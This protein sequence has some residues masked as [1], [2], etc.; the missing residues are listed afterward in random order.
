M[1]TF[2]SAG[3]FEYQFKTLPPYRVVCKICHLP[4]RH[5]HLTV[6]CGHVFC[7]S[8]LDELEN[9]KSIVNNICP[10][11]RSE[12]FV[13]FSNKQIDRE[14]KSLLVYCTNKGRG[15]EWQGEVNYI[16]NHLT[17]EGGCEYEDVICTGGCGGVIQRRGLT[18]HVETECPHRKVNCQYCQLGGEHW[19]IEGKHKEECAEYPLAC[20][21]KCEEAGCIARKD[22]DEH[23]SRCPLEVIDCEYET[24]GC[25]VWMTRQT[26]K[27]HNKE[28]MEHHLH[29]TKCKLV[30]TNCKLSEMK[31]KTIAELGEALQKLAQE[32]AQTKQEL[33]QTKQ[34]LF[35]VENQFAYM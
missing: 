34:E 17:K 20:P 5:P 2:S 14:V 13:T 21:N 10:V 7:K 6:C 35:D 27:E 18:K 28:K 4:S 15:C 29:L 8:C 9:A 1:T 30:E 32:L 24:M 33:A 3:G 12:D 19:F 23:R 22:M 31:S 26:Q 11:C 25:E 16:D